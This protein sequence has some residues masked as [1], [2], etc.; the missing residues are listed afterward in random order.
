MKTPILPPQLAPI[1]FHEKS[2]WRDGAKVAQVQE[3][4]AQSDVSDF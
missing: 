1:K 3:D 4:D 2:L